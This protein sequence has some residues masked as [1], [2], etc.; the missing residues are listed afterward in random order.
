[1]AAGKKRP[2]HGGTKAWVEAAAVLVALLAG[3]G[4][5]QQRAP[6]ENG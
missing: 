5:A 1:M 4:S 2:R 3:A 6:V